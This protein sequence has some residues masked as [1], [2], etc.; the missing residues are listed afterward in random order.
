MEVR[1]FK[2]SERQLML[3]SIEKIWRRNHAYVRM[4]EVLEHF[5]LHSPYR[6][7]FAGEDNY[8]FLGMWDGDRVVGLRG[9]IPQRFNVFGKEYLSTTGTIWCTDKSSKRKGHPI[10]GL[11]LMESYSDHVI[12][13]NV[14]MGLTD[15]SYRVNA[16]MGH[17]MTRD[18]PRWV[19]I[20]R[21]DD[22]L[23]NLLPENTNPMYLSETRLIDCD[24]L[25]KTSIDELDQGKWDEFYF[26]EF[27]PL[28]VGTQRDYRFLH[29]RYE[30]SPVLRYRIVTVEDGDGKY[31]GLAVF[32][33]EPILN[34]RFALGRIV[35]F[36]CV[37]ADASIVL[38]NA[39]L[40][41]F[42][43]VLAWDFYCLSSITAF[44]LETVGFRRIPEWMDQVMMPT[45]CNPLEYDRLKIR[46]SVFLDE[47]L[48]NQIDGLAEIPW[49][50]TR[51]DGTQDRAN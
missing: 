51:G 16:A 46:A 31:L 2:K 37:R 18:F 20:N 44:G 22:A 43:D 3:D 38:A 13:A 11:A 39:V 5:V 14:G 7:E 50:I 25:L 48:R 36:I 15:F 1:F 9:I 41:T 27:A 49:Y 26:K 40:K 8:S 30:Q 32:R 35:E 10:N 21:K 42:P 28:T 6:A 23:K 19:A 4:P 12:W 45:R 47:R 17:Y 29:W 24:G 33:R 34:G